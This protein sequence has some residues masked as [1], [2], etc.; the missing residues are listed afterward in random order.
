MNDQDWIE[1]KDGRRVTLK[2]AQPSCSPRLLTYLGSLGR[3]TD[4]I[5]TCEQDL[6]SL[7]KVQAQLEHIENGSFYSLLAIDPESDLVVG[8]VSFRFS[9]RLKL[10]HIADL[11]IGVLTSHRGTAFGSG[12]LRTGIEDM[13][14]REGIERI[15]LTVLSRNE[16]ALHMY[17][18]FGFVREGLKVRS[19]KQP[20]GRYEDEIIMGLWIE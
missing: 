13:R 18:R 7:D 14:E 11:G 3:S 15:E 19:F 16:H 1:L 5:L 8:A 12:L 20:D 2:Y 9:E 10:S 4:T 17:E 6:P